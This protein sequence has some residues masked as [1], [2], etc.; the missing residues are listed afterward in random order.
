MMDRHGLRRETLY[1]APENIPSSWSRGPLRPHSAPLARESP[2]ERRRITVQGMVQSAGFRSF[3]SKLA[4]RW[5]LS[6]HL[7]NDSTGVI[8]E[9]QGIEPSIE[10]F[11]EA[12]LT[13]VP[14]LAHINA[15]N[16]ELLPISSDEGSF[17]EIKGEQRPMT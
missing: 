1:Y 6:G 15:I 3:V 16:T 8:V 10:G 9:V 4:R 11:L 13:D 12:L 5:K 17:T 14:P 7:L 2:L